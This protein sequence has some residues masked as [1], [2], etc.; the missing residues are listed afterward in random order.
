[1]SSSLRPQGLLHASLP[2]PSPAPRACSSS[3]PLS[4]MPSTHLILLITFS[5]CPQ[6]L[7]ASGSFLM[8]QFFASS[9]QSIGVSATLSVLPMNSVQ[10]LSHIRPFAIPWTAAHQA[11]LSVTNSQSLLKL[12]SIELVMPSNHLIL[13]SP[14]L[15]L[16]SIFTSIRVFSN[17]LTHCIRWPKYW[18]FNISSSNEYSVWFPS[19]LT[20]LI[21]LQSKELS[22]VFSNTKKINPEYFLEGLMLKLKLQY[23]GEEPT[24]WKRP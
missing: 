20:G 12:M 16:L 17:E 18:S 23:F 21:S 5:S 24:H 22:G 3:R 4:V 2:Y 15:L 9:G 7:P 1:M 10:S 6:S 8:S 11:S 19:G 13:C 14:L